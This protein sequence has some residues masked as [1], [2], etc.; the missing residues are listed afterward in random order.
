M[1]AHAK[2]TVVSTTVVVSQ[3]HA[4][5]QVAFACARVPLGFQAL[6]VSIRTVRLSVGAP[7]FASQSFKVLAETPFPII[8]VDLR[9]VAAKSHILIC[10]YF[11]IQEL[12]T[13]IEA[14]IC[15]YIQASFTVIASHATLSCAHHCDIE[16]SIN[17]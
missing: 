13:G 14:N 11:Q 8:F 10:K 5:F 12:K 4:I 7:T 1:K 17:E 9:V 3:V 15:S 2:V 6:F 16:F